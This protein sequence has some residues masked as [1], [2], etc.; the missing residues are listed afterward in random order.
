MGSVYHPILHCGG[1]AEAMSFCREKG[2]AICFSS[3]GA[4]YMMQTVRQYGTDNRQ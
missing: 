2:L 4:E 1:I 3:E